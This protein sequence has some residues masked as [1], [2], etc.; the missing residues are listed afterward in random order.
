MARLMGS[1]VVNGVL[2]KHFMH[3]EGGEKKLTIQRVQDS[4]PIL[5]ANREQFNSASSSYG[6]SDLQKVASIPIV[7]LE[8]I[9]TAR[10]IKFPELMAC[11]TDRAKSIWNEILNGRDFRAFRTKPGV[12]KVHGN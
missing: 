7:V 3:E 1:E 11:K 5:M 12:V 10:G 4:E 9:C 2:E 8:N 6:K